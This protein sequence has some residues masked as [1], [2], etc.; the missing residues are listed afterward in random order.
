MVDEPIFAPRSRLKEALQEAQNV[1]EQYYDEHAYKLEYADY[2]YEDEQFNFSFEVVPRE[3]HIITDKFEFQAD[4]ADIVTVQYVDA[5]ENAP[6]NVTFSV[7]GKEIEK[8]HDT[9]TPLEITTNHVGDV[10]V[11]VLENEE[12]GTLVLR[13]IS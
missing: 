1:F 12:A 3:P 8:S 10:E 7:N 2:T 6:D 9:R 5:T 4:G 11:L 13:A